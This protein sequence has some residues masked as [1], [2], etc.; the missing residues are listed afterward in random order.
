MWLRVIGYVYG[1][2]L[3]V[4]FR[5]MAMAMC[6]TICLGVCLCVGLCLVLGLWLWLRA[7]VLVWHREIAVM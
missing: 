2:G 3:C 7:L 4:W 5:A 6:L 1:F